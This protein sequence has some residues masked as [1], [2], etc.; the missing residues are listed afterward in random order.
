MQLRAQREQQ[1]QHNPPHSIH[2]LRAVFKG[3]NVLHDH[4]ETGTWKKLNVSAR[5]MHWCQLVI[6]VSH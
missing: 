6:Q 3:V 1:C 4:I 2:W 5:H